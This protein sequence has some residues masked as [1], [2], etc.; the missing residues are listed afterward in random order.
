MLYT[1]G[2]D[3][4]YFSKAPGRLAAFGGNSSMTPE[5]YPEAG[6]MWHHL[7]RN[8][9]TFR[10]YGEGFEFAGGPEDEGMEET[11]IREVINMPMPKVLYDNTCRDYANFNLNIPDLYRYEQFK[12][13]IRK[14]QDG[15]KPFPHFLNIYICCDHG[16]G[17]NPKIGYKYRASYMAD[18]DMALGKMVEY[19]SHTPYWKHMAIFVTQ[20][21]SGS[22]PDHIDAQRSV[23]MVISPYA[24]RHYV[25]HR[26]TTIT[27]MH[28]TLYEIFGLPPLNL[29]DAL[30]NDFSD[31]F[32]SKPDFTP[33]TAVEIDHRLF[34]WPAVRNPKDPEYKLAAKLPSVQRDTWKP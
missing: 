22:E 25:S 23:L 27:S 8:S 9:I 30:S 1:L 18:N 33:Y 29:F 7:A 16:A 10:N 24:K 13:D 34:D 4:N 26:H 12:R 5:D 2:W 17:E 28:R 14:Y 32:T 20:D 21:D 6:S 15:T 11:G 31:S 3:F 19:L